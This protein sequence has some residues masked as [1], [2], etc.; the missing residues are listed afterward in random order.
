[1]SSWKIFFS[2]IP[3]SSLI[4]NCAQLEGIF[5]CSFFL[6]NQFPIEIKG[7]NPGHIVWSLTCMSAITR[8]PKPETV[9]TMETLSSRKR[10]VN[11]GRQ[12]LSGCGN[13]YIMIWET[14]V[15]KVYCADHTYTTIRLPINSTVG[16]IVLSARDKLCLGHDPVLC[17][18]KS[19]GERV[20]FREKDR[21]IMMS[22]SLNGRLFIAPREHLDALTPVPEQEGPNSSTMHVIEVMSTKELATQITHY[23]WELFMAVHEQEMLNKVFGPTVFQEGVAANLEQFLR[24]FDQLQY[25]VVTEMVLLNNV[26][27]RV[28]LLRKFIKLAQHCKELNNFHA[29]FAI[30]MGLGHLAVSR[31]SQTWEKLPGKVK[32]MFSEF[33]TVMEPVRNHRSYR[34]AVSKLTSPIIPF[35]PLLIKDMTFTNEGNKTYYDNMV[36]FEKMHMIAQTL[37]TVRFCRRN[38]LEPESPETMK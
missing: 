23:D 2:P 32:K 17:E 34:L 26:G 15:T 3:S 30:T 36:N 10:N 25:W 27:K 16:D 24:R 37:R 14:T 11:Q 35:M 13:L 31:L 8:T 21:C 18:V 22:L 9:R 19:N 7:K 28:Q 33:E 29:F 38:H 20:L 12:L 1:M 4:T 5:T 6:S